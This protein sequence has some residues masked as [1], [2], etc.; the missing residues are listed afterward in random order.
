MDIINFFVFHSDINLKWQVFIFIIKNNRGNQNICYLCAIF[1]RGMKRFY[2]LCLTL[3]S[4]FSCLGQA[5]YTEEFAV[6]DTNHLFLD[7][8]MPSLHATD[9]TYPCLIYVFG[10]GFMEGKRNDSVSVKAFEQLS[11]KGYVVVAIDYRLGLKGI[12]KMGASH[13]KTL[14]HAIRIAVEDLYSATN[15]VYKNA[16]RFHINPNIFTKI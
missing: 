8:Y 6:K 1:Q 7:V 10:G 13:V 9:S 2:F 15:Y 11:E 3:V 16:S 4:F 5:N 12:H 14:E